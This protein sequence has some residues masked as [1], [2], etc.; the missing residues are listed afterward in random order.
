MEL[1]EEGGGS[2]WEAEVVVVGGGGVWVVACRVFGGGLCEDV[3]ED[4]ED[5]V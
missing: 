5:D 1:G 2:D 3:D 4:D